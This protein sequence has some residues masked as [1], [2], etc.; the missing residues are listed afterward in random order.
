MCLL[1]TA[2]G[3]RSVKMEFL[4]TSLEM[5]EDLPDELKK[6]V[7]ASAEQ[8]LIREEGK[9]GFRG[10]IFRDGRNRFLA[11][12]LYD[13]WRMICLCGG[14]A[15]DPSPALQILERAFRRGELTPIDTA[16][17][18]CL[19]YA[20]D[21]TADPEELAAFARDREDPSGLLAEN[22]HDDPETMVCF[23]VEVAEMMKE[24]GLC[25]PE[26]GWRE[27]LADYASRAD[28]LPPGDG[29][30]FESGGLASYA[31]E[32]AGIPPDEE[33][34][35]WFAEW[36]ELYE[37][38][39][40][41]SWDDLLLLSGEYWPLSSRFRTGDVLRRRASEFIRNNLDTYLS[42]SWQSHLCYAYLKPVPG[43]LGSG[44]RSSCAKRAA[45]S[46]ASCVTSLNEVSPEATLYGFLLLRAAGADEG[47]TEAVRTCEKEVS[48]LMEKEN[49]SDPG[50]IPGLVRSAWSLVLLTE[51]FAEAG[52]NL[53]DSLEFRKWV[54][55]LAEKCASGAC[56]DPRT[57]LHLCELLEGSL[58]PAF[59][60][61]LVSYTDLCLQEEVFRKSIYMTDLYE[62]DQYT[63]AGK[64]TRD[65]VLAALSGLGEGGLFCPEPGMVPDLSS[66]FSVCV[67][68][69]RFGDFAG[70]PECRA[71]PDAVRK[72]FYKE[73]KEDLDLKEL[74]YLCAITSQGGLHVESKSPG[75][76]ESVV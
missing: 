49:G 35:K 50:T 34:T 3:V 52:E 51:Q 74:Y 69:S 76:S 43:L 16:A 8:D 62:I 14:E 44:E 11:E 64:V 54:R 2:C 25:L 5:V 67:L 29:D 46:Y 26:T 59:R 42:D 73:L 39:E 27:A 57:L 41:M 12:D 18:L 17:F 68:E 66:T 72:A 22:D 13:S 56:P 45:A 36:D 38:M 15:P 4:E 31:R 55:L 63:G 75:N 20:G 7:L 48:A 65:M 60:K 47:G 1:L 58:P 6:A 71:D 19:K 21:G 37:Q 10:G 23:T 30:L 70:T 24:A 40:I 33:E 61:Y 53:A 28:Y 9:T 32:C